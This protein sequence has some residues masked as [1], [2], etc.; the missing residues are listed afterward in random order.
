MLHYKTLQV[1][2][3]LDRAVQ[4]PFYIDT[5]E[6]KCIFVEKKATGTQLLEISCDDDSDNRLNVEVL[7]ST[8]RACCCNNNH[9]E[10]NGKIDCEDG[11]QNGDCR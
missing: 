6:L 9:V 2:V 11:V 8:N 1:E 10:A 3:V 4:K 7:L 5:K